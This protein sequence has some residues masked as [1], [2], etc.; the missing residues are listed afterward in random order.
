M[1]T[2]HKGADPLL[3]MDIAALAATVSKSV[4]TCQPGESLGAAMHAAAT[5][6]QQAPAA[7]GSRVATLVV[8]HDLSWERSRSSSS[9]SSSEGQLAAAG[10]EKGAVGVIQEGS[11]EARFLRDCAAALQACPRGKAA[12]L[13]GGTASLA[14]GGWGGFLAFL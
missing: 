6:A 4:H 14:E 2:W 7:G 1:A 5:E 12:L 13:V 3:N 10:E 9:G 8:P 11:P